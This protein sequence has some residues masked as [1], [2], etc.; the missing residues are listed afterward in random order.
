MD[1]TIWSLVPIELLEMILLWVPF[2]TLIQI[3]SIS[4][5]CYELLWQPTFTNS[6]LNNHI[7]E[8]GFLVELLIS[9]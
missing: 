3:G 7:T 5:H 1:P 9:Y 4:K 8:V 2:L 6:W